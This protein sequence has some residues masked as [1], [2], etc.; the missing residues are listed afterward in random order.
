MWFRVPAERAQSDVE[1]DYLTDVGPQFIGL[2]ASKTIRF[3]LDL[4][5]PNRQRTELELACVIGRSGAHQRCVLAGNDHESAY[6]GTPIRLNDCPLNF[7]RILCLG[8][9]ARNKEECN[10]LN[11]GIG[12][13]SHRRFTPVWV[14]KVCE[15]KSRRPIGGS[16]GNHSNAATKRLSVI[17]LFV[18]EA[19]VKSWEHTQPF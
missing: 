8:H 1:P 4:I 19:M 16:Q 17:L 6:Y 5:A 13:R 18:R 12:A 9:K 3:Y 2:P 7:S 11:R 10:E 15:N 14:T